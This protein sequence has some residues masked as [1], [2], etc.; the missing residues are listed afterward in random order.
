EEFTKYLE[1]YELRSLIKRYSD[2]IRYPIRMEVTGSR[3][4]ED[5][6]EQ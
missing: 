1:E 5:S 4:K 3:K 2:Y 6:D